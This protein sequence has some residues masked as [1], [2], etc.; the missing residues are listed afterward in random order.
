MNNTI[1]QLKQLRLGGMAKALSEQL[2]QPQLQG[3]SFDERLAFMVDREVLHRSNR[4]VAHLIRSAKLKQQ[5]MIENVD[6]NHQRGLDR[7]RFTGFLSGEF[8]SRQQNLLFT[9][10]TGCGKSYLSCAIGNQA[11][12][13]GFSVRYISMPR[14]LEE[15]VIAHADGSYSKFLT[16]ILKTDVLILDDFGLAP[17]LNPEQRRDFFNIIDDRHQIKSTIITSQLPVKHWHDYIGEP[18]LADAILDR[19]LE[20]SHRIELSGPSLRKAKNLASS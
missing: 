9:G 12:R 3:L 15:L 11:C 16:Q 6:Y 14:F 10:P 5:A 19:L 2:E 7:S 17:A 4:R 13:L 20:K 8:I 18:T 1:E